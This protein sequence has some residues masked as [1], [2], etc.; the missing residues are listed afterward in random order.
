[1]CDNVSVQDMTATVDET[2]EIQTFSAMTSCGATALSL[3]GSYSWISLH[4]DA[5]TDSVTI[6]LA[7]TDNADAG[8]YSLT[9][10]T[11]YPD[12]P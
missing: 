6:T 8:E 12:V 9:L 1:M 5:P 2:A 3:S 11:T 10:T 4:H 7:P